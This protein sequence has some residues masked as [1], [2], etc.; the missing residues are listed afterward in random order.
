MADA[1]LTFPGSDLPTPERW[2]KRW[3]I[4]A[5]ALLALA[6]TVAYL[7]WRT[8]ATI[9][10]RWWWIAIPLLLLE[11]HAAVGLG[12]FTFSLWDLDASKPPA[13]R[14]A[15]PH[16]IAVLIPTYNEPVEILLPTVAAA[17]ALRPAHETWVLDD[18]DRP[19][20]A[21]LAAELGARYL[22]RTDR[23]HAKAGNL[24]HA[25]SVID[26]DLVAILDADHVA[27]PGFLT[28]TLPYFDDPRLA[29][30]QTPQD[31]Y[32]RDSFEHE[33]DY[34]EQA[35]FYRVLQAGKNR[36][37]AAFWCGTG[38]VVR[39]DA[40]RDVGGVA[41]ETVT[42]DIHTTI[43]FHRRG[44]KSVYHNEVL[45]RGLAAADAE[46]YATQRLRWGTGAMQVL[47]SPDNP[48]FCRGLTLPQRLAYAST[49]LGW[50]DAWRSLG[51]VVA[52]LAVVATGAVPIQ[53]PAALFALVFA[54]T[55]VAQRVALTLLGRGKAPQ[56]LSVVFEM[57]RMAANLRA[58]LTL[59]IPGPRRFSVT[60]K[61]RQ[62]DGRRRVPPPL[63]L[64]ALLAASAA[65]TAWF[66][67]TAV[68]RTSV[69]YDVAWAAYGAFGWLVVNA[70]LVGVAATRIMAARFAGE[71][72]SSVRF[73]LDLDGTLDGEPCQVRDLSITG[74]Q[75][76]LSGQCSR[77]ERHALELPNLGVR[78]DLEV[79]SI[80]PRGD[81]VHQLGAAFVPGQLGDVAR[82]A[83]GMFHGVLPPDVDD[84]AD[85]FATARGRRRHR[86]SA[87]RLGWAMPALLLI[88]AAALRRDA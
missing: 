40:L 87:A 33:R 61:G 16:K 8:V 76:V 5:S 64:V 12:L 4:R 43:R 26:A 72:R 25:L 81:G 28:H 17:V 63:L 69:T 70:A 79:R 48:L 31:F 14:L 86:R 30:V 83:L 9:D 58:T 65:M 73:G 10:L 66:A 46:Q 1:L 80:T 68:G 35:L 60:P 23:S 29:V 42:E 74:A 3:L 32:N 84:L 88:A 39:V 85:E 75:V 34:Q 51:Y 49:L 59:L 19:E 82:L 44:W 24:N 36:W 27:A 53:A 52:P 62:G 41:T 6:I 67:L 7:G 55:F 2:T 13:P 77:D 15:S 21:A 22:T 18:G 78:L 45:A 56:L 20:V 38:A 50:F 57:V 71:R 54:I 47:R 37:G 11:V